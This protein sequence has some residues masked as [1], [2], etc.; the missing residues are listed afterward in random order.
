MF[1][2]A[3][4]NLKIVQ[5]KGDPEN[6][7]LPTKLQPGDTVLVQN[8][9]TGP[10]D[11]KYV[12]DYCIVALTGNQVEVR[13]LIR[14]PT[15]MNHVKHVIIFSLQINI[16]N[17]YLIILPLEGKLHSEWILIRYWI[18]IGIWQ[19][20]IILQI[21]DRLILKLHGYLPTV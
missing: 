8:H 7:P 2:I 17:K 1:E 11:P 3:A 13:P 21:L 20:L 6:K 9:N 19:I 12:G 16:L 5:E 10:F 14:G 18:Y 4:A 15:E